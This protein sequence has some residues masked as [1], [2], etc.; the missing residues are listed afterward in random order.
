MHSPAI[1]ELQ[2]S[3]KK[4]KVFNY[5]E[6]DIVVPVVRVVVVAIRNTAVVIVV[7]PTTAAKEAPQLESLSQ[8]NPPF[9]PP[10]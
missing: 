10:L 1:R 6:T 3:G 4:K 2:N 7:V 9:I 8:E 5:T